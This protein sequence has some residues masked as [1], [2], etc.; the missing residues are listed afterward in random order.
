MTMRTLPFLVLAGCDPFGHWPDGGQSVEGPL[1]DRAVVPS[2]DGGV[3]AP[4]STRSLSGGT[5]RGG[6]SSSEMRNSPVTR[7]MNP[8]ITPSMAAG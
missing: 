8:E 1:W 2:A 5:T 4:R 6:G 7:G 3:S